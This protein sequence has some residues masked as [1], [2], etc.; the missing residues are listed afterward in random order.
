MK[1]LIGRNLSSLAPDV[2]GV[3]GGG[4]EEHCRS[5]G[6][7]ALEV[8]L[9]VEANVVE[10]ILRNIFIKVKLYLQVGHGGS[11]LGFIEFDML[12]SKAWPIVLG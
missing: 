12:W 6:A 5:A 9:L 2:W 7:L 11:A 1:D 10:I 8:E 3:S 4:V